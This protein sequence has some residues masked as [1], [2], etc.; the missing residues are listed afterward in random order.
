MGRKTGKKRMPSTD[1]LTRDHLQTL[2]IRLHTIYRY[3]DHKPLTNNWNKVTY[4]LQIRWLQTT[5][6]NLKQG[7]KP[8]TTTL[9]T[10][11]L[12]TFEIKPHTIYKHVDHKPPTNTWNKDTYHPQIRWLQTTYRHVKQGYRPHTA[13]L[14]TNHLQTLDIRPQTTHRYVDY[15]TSTNI[16]SKA[17]HNLQIRWVAV[18]L[19]TTA[20]NNQMISF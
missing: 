15:K 1:T 20:P 17:T 12:Q 7:Y 19:L 14:A 16:W 11:H 8:L 9:A 13:T 18:W 10:D 6:R 3:V 2:E 5:Y 4:H